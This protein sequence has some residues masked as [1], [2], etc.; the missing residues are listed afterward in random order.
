MTVVTLRGQKGAP[1]PLD[2]KFQAVVSCCARLLS[3]PAI[4]PTPQYTLAFCVYSI[5]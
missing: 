1:D 2:L 5:P 4:S 3:A